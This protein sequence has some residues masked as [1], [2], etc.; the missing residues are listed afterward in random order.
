MVGYGISSTGGKTGHKRWWGAGFFGTY[1]DWFGASLD[2]RDNGEY[3]DNTDRT[4]AF[5]PV[6]GAAIKGAPNGIE[7]TELTGAINFNLAVGIGIY[8]EGAS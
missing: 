1:G 3:G 5:S 2:L 8:S 6:T 4:K 7:Y